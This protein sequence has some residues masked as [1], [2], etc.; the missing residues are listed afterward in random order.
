MLKRTWSLL[1]VLTLCAAPAAAFAPDRAANDRHLAN[2]R[3]SALQRV[4]CG[5]VRLLDLDGGARAGGRTRDADQPRRISAGDDLGGQVDP[6][7]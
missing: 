2:E 4:W 3:Q 7:G 5:L 6:D 1:L